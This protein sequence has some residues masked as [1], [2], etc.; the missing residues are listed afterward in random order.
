MKAFQEQEFAVREPWETQAPNEVAPGISR[1]RPPKAASLR[2][3]RVGDGLARRV[4]ARLPLSVAVIDADAKLSLWNEKAS[5]LFGCPPLMAAERPSLAEML[6]RIR[7]LTNPQRDRIVT[8]ALA[9]IEVG[10]RAEPDGC[11]RLSLGRASHI[12]IQIHGLGTGHWMLIFDDGKVTAA[13]NAT[14]RAP[15]DAWLDSLTGLSNRRHFSQV[16]RQAIDCATAETHQA[17][18]LIDLDRFA[19]IN[20][21]LG[22]PVGDALLCLVAQRLRREKRDEDL[23]ARLGGDEFALLVPN[24][25]RAETLAARVIGTLGQPFLVEGHQVTIGASIGIARFPDHGTSTDDLMRHADLALF[26]AKSAGGQSWQLF[27]GALASNAR[28]PK[29][30]AADLRKALTLRQISVVYQPYG[31]LRS[32]ALTGFEA[33]PRWDQGLVSDSMFTTL[34]EGNKFIVTLGEWAL[35]TACM[36]AVGWPVPQGSAPLTVAVRVASRQLREPDRL[37][38]AV[39]LALEDSGLAPGR[40]KLQISETSLRG[41]EDD[42]LSI[43][44]RLRPL[45]VGITLADCTIGPSLLDHLESFPFHDIALAWGSHSDRRVSAAEAGA[46]SALSATGIDQIGCYFGGPPTLTSGVAEVMRLHATPDNTISG[47]YCECQAP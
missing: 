34:V 11:L 37:V 36:E 30:L 5:N 3:N 23:L 15:E 27:D 26:Q 4:L 44:H 1:P 24:C 25:D 28:T 14:L 31:D 6:A 20:E 46:L 32:G 41:N 39:R 19:P 9:H 33:R 40:L 8:F 22:Y 29:E 17:V 47:T 12:A 7:N 13:G 16:L 38:E 21:T 2:R 18:L 42:V 35:K 43:L 45:G 10:D